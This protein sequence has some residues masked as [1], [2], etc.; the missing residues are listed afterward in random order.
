M[1]FVEDRWLS[2][3]LGYPVQILELPGGDRA[4]DPAEV[5]RAARELSRGRRVMLFA[6]L[7]AGEIAAAR[8]LGLAGFYP[9]DLAVSL[10][11]P[12]AAAGADGG[13]V[14]AD[15][16]SDPQRE[17]V[18][19]I[20]RD[21]FVFSRFHQDPLIGKAAADGVKR[22]WVAN[23]LA[24]NRGDALFV[25][26]REGQAA[27]FLASLVVADPSG[28]AAVVDLVAV[29]PRW[30]GRGVGG[31]LLDHFRQHYHG[32]CSGVLVGTQINNAP[33][34]RLYQARGFVVTGGHLV[35]HAHFRD[36][37]KMQ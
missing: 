11:G 17:Q 5:G 25:A 13:V 31:C 21:S 2:E 18:L 7:P 22:A 29:G 16:L 14:T 23:C 27:G 32:R 28:E 4:P 26:L 37:E 15:A 36:G 9:V 35:L 10:R 19:D 3:R 24:G 6:K 20:A 34:L 1:R 30:Q 8:S 33:S 12:T